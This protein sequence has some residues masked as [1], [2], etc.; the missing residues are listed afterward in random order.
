MFFI[1]EDIIQPIG[2]GGMRLI[3]DRTVQIDAAGNAEKIIFDVWDGIAVSFDSMSVIRE[4][5]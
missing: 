5:T 2:S 3:G 1:S 4:T